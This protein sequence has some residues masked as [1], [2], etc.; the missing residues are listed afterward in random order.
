[1]H[2][3]TFRARSMRDALAMV[4][5]EFGP[6]ASILHTREVAPGG[7][8][9]VWRAPMVEVAATPDRAP[10]AEQASRAARAVAA[11]VAARGGAARK[12]EAPRPARTADS[13]AAGAAS[14]YAKLIAAD[15]SG[16]FARGVVRGLPAAGAG[17]AALCDAI[18]QLL[19]VAGPI[20][21]Q[22]GGRR[23]A[24][25]I[26]P[27]GVGKTTTLAKLAANFRVREGRRVGLV[28]V[29]TYRVA[30]VEQL[31]TYAQIV[32]LP[33]EVV[34]DAAQ[35]RAALE[36]L[37]GVELVLI[38]T[39][40]R[41]P[42]D[43][44]QIDELRRLLAAAEPDET[45][46]VASVTAG[47]HA[48]RDTLARFAAVGPTRVLLTKFDEAPTTGHIAAP[49]AECG[50]PVSY[51]TDGQNVPEDIA[52]AEPTGLARRLLGGAPR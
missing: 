26:G 45:H 6:G 15:F 21:L 7:I 48:L 34:A 46:L 35:M 9:R 1:M 2:I 52:V 22:R 8:A 19:P 31:R 33:M 37:S 29:D 12:S 20:G 32:D 23:V 27:T 41:S 50:L 24:A 5:A 18:G 40:G 13:A 14:I 42:R 43:S 36:R 38:D 39:A 4:R 47:P 51:L 11:P 44:A 10:L 3:K 16:E 49:L 30:A 25:L 17:E 28:T